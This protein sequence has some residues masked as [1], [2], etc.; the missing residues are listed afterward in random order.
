M[1]IQYSLVY[2]QI[3]GKYLATN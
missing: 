2:I 1:C 3:I